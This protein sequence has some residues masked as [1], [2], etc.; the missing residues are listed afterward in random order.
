MACNV[1]SELFWKTNV[2]SLQYKTEFWYHKLGDVCQ[3]NV[4]A[5]F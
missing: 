5:Y 2:D 3:E 1:F 4:R